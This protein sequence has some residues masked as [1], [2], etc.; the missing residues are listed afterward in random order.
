MNR[1][2]SRVQVIGQYPVQLVQRHFR[3]CVRANC[4]ALRLSANVARATPSPAA[5]TY[6]RPSSGFHDMNQPLIRGWS[7]AGSLP[8]ITG[9]VRMSAPLCGVAP[10]LRHPMFDNIWFPGFHVVTNSYICRIPDSFPNR[11]MLQR[12]MNVCECSL[13]PWPPMPMC[14]LTHRQHPNIVEQSTATHAAAHHVGFPTQA[15][16]EG[17]AGG[18]RALRAK[19]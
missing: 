8:A 5:A 10:L 15:R 3:S 2:N 11:R 13:M 1:D 6:H 14:A 9:Y 17:R 19:R 16:R 18:K 7:I 12:N 4:T